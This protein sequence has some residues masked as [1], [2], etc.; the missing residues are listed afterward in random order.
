MLDPKIIS[1]C[2]PVSRVRLAPNKSGLEMERKSMLQGK[3]LE[4]KRGKVRG[5]S[6][7]SLHNLAFL[8]TTSRVKFSS[9]LTL[10]YGQEFPTCGK[11][12]KAHLNRFLVWLRGQEVGGDKVEYIWFLEFQRRNAPHYH[13]LLNREQPAKE[14]RDK[15]ARVWCKI[16]ATSEQ[17]YGLMLAVHSYDKC[18]EKRMWQAAKSEDGLRRYAVKYACK[19]KQKTVPESFLNVG[20]FWGASR[21][22]RAQDEK[23]PESPMNEEMF[24][25]LL[26]DV[27]RGDIAEWEVLPKHIYLDPTVAAAGL[28]R[29]FGK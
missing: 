7:R 11:E 3:P 4:S 15:A 23:W 17:Q 21:G 26:T 2:Y 29:W 8:A 18:E 20:R 16:G 5:L 1:T 12:S 19:R 14:L 27:G 28:E 24:R 10:T 9:F 6:G 25:E 22:V 13:I